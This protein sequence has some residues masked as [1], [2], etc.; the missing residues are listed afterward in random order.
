LAEWLTMKRF[1]SFF[2]VSLALDVAPGPD[3]LFVFA[4]SL[5][6]GWSAGVLVT[7]GLCSGAGW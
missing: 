5:A 1:W 2:M 4:Q 6:H 7:L 3:I